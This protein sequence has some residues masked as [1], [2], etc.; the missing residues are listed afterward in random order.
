MT[1]KQIGEEIRQIRQRQEV[2]FQFLAERGLFCNSVYRVERGEN[3]ALGT[4]FRYTYYLNARL[5]LDG[6]DMSTAEELGQV[7]HQR[8]TE[9]GQSLRAV[10]EATGLSE[11]Q[12][13]DIEKAR[14]GKVES[15]E[16]Y[17]DELGARLN[18]RELNYGALTTLT[19]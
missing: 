2:S 3:Y 12:I 14:G 6:V 11:R 1:I 19:T 7:L 9:H 5:T 17:L 4:L 13:I 8:R 16:R 18:V 15:L 10:A